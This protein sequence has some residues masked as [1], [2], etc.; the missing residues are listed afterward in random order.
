MNRGTSSFSTAS[1]PPGHS[2]AEQGG[3]L[4]RIALVY[5]DP[6]TRKVLAFWLRYA[7][8]DVAL[9]RCD[10]AACD[11]ANRV[12]PDLVLLDYDL[13]DGQGPRVLA[14]K[15][16]HAGD[17]DY[18]TQFRVAQA[19]P[20]TVEIRASGAEGTYRLQ[21]NRWPASPLDQQSPGC[22]ALPPFRSPRKGKLLTSGCAF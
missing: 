17:P 11:L 8:Y 20:A 4:H 5:K 2:P 7:G 6:M 15:T 18:Y 9:C 19:G 16:L 22:C 13:P 10:E 21:V 1:I 3:K 12:R 14:S